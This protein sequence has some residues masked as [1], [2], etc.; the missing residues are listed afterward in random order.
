MGQLPKPL[1]PAQLDALRVKA[2]GQPAQARPA[3]AAEV[4]YETGI[5]GLG[6]IVERIQALETQNKELSARMETLEGQ[7]ALL[8]AAEKPAARAHTATSTGR[9]GASEVN[10]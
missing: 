7:I 1:S 4:A 10:H 6:P 3:T 9:A 5:R 2:Q 8:L